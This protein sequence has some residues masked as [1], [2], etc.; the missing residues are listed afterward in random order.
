MD[1]RKLDNLSYQSRYDDYI[2]Y[3]KTDNFY[4]DINTNTKRM[5]FVD[6]MVAFS[7]DSDFLYYFDTC[8]IIV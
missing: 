5:R 1:Y 8:M 2:I 7:V 6:S 3:L 4:R